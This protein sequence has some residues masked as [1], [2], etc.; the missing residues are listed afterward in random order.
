MMSELPTSRIAMSRAKEPS[1]LITAD[2][3]TD[4]LE[5]EASVADCLRAMCEVPN[6]DPI[7]EQV[8]KDT[9][10]VISHWQCRD[11]PVYMVRC[12]RADGRLNVYGHADKS[13]GFYGDSV[14][15]SDLVRYAKDKNTLLKG[16]S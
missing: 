9:K 16:P 7:L 13:N 3:A 11:A 10:L 8:T 2:R 15:I 14:T 5:A 4:M 12:F 1:K 6:I